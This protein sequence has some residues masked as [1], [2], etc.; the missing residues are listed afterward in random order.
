MRMLG[1]MTVAEVAEVTG[2]AP[3]TIDRDWRAA[4][5]WLELQLRS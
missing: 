2:R 5:A 1:G 4:R 3:R